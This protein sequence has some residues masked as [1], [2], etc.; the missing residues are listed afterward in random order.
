LIAEQIADH[1]GALRSG[2][3]SARPSIPRPIQL[4]MELAGEKVN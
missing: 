1:L 3:I 2:V 4:G